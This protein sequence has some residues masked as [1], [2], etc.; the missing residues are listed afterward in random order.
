MISKKAKFT[1]KAFVVFRSKA[2]ADTV[3]KHEKFPFR[4]CWRATKS[5]CNPMDRIFAERADDPNDVIWENASVSNCSRFGR[6][7]LTGIIAA[8][9]I[10]V[11]IFALVYINSVKNNAQGSI[12]VLKEAGTTV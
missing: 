3:Y 7:I 4:K 6:R 5:I 2:D 10:M 12:F 11:N 8:V 9:F 1:G